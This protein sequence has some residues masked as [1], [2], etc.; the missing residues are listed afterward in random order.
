MRKQYASEITK[1]YLIELGVEEVDPA[2]RYIIVKGKAAP[3]HY[4]PNEKRHY[5]R[6][7]LYDPKIRQETP[8]EKRKN[9]TGQFHIPVHVINYVWNRGNRPSGYVI[10]HINNDPQDN[11][12][13]NLQLLT[14]AENLAKEKGESKRVIESRWLGSSKEYYEKKLKIALEEYEEAKLLHNAEETHKLRSKIAY[15][16]ARLRFFIS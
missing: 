11:R 8:K 16:K 2:G 4:N 5:L 15:Y 7:S 10:D 9:N 13:E 6:I 14:P 3:F 1:E 12:I